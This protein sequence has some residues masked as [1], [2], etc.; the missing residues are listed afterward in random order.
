VIPVLRSATADDVPILL[1]IEQES[2]SSQAWDAR[3]FLRYD[4]TVALVDGRIAGFLVARQ[5]FAGT[6]EARPEREILN[7]AVA[8]AFRRLGIATA[9]L[10]NELEF[11]ATHFLEVRESNVVARTL[12]RKLGFAEIGTRPDYYNDPIEKAIVMRRK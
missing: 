3:N 7:L 2:F 11:Q 6:T 8:S 4:C 5:T 12:Y 9:L 1:E 10:K